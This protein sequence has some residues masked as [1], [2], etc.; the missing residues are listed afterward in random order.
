MTIEQLS[1]SSVKYTLSKSELDEYNLNFHSM[2]KYDVYT[3]SLIAD[4]IAFAEAKQSISVDFS[5]NE[6][7]V[8]AFSCNNGNCIIYISLV[9]RYDRS[10]LDLPVSNFMVCK[11]NS[12]DVLVRL[13]KQ[14]VK[15]STMD[16]SNSA[17]YR[18]DSTFLL[19]IEFTKKS[20]EKILYSVIEFCE[21]S[22]KR[23]SAELV[24]EYWECL[25]YDNAIQR[26]QS[27]T[28]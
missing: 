8:E 25:A 5:N 4:L 1:N 12:L 22:I 13:S 7:Y 2:S 23:P 16:I 14:L 10:R 21:Y 18:Q 20:F 11:S 9:N 15:F 3:R 19:C 24:N 27:L 17:L 26:L 28:I 6:V